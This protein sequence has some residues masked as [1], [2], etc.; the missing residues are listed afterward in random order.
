MES[1]RGVVF[2]RCGYSDVD[3]SFPK[4]PQLPM[5]QCTAY[6]RANDPSCDSGSDDLS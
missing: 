5:L 3:A 2:Y 6:E 4:Y 1:V